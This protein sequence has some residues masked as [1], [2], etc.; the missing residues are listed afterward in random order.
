MINKR[1]LQCRLYILHLH[2]KR[3][4]NFTRVGVWLI[5]F[6]QIIKST[7]SVGCIII[8]SKRIHKMYAGMCVVFRKHRFICEGIFLWHTHRWKEHND[9]MWRVIWNNAFSPPIY[10]TLPK[11]ILNL[12]YIVDR[13]KYVSLLGGV[14][15]QISISATTCGGGCRGKCI[16]VSYAIYLPIYTYIYIYLFC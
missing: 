2:L 4:I 7:F 15:M 3:T 1:C 13:G 10:G 11:R 14:F 9:W 6:T 8:L 16:S 12:C 5:L